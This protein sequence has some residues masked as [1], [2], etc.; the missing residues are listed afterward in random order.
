MYRMM[1]GCTLVLLG[2]SLTIFC[3]VL[4]TMLHFFWMYYGMTNW[5]WRMC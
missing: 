5:C 3:W 2:W 1:V 4:Y